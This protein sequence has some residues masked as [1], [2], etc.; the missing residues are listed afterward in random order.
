MKQTLIILITLFA[1]PHVN[2]AAESTADSLRTLIATAEGVDKLKEYQNLS[3]HYM[4]NILRE[5][6]IDTLLQISDEM[7]AEARRQ[8][9]TNYQGLA[10]SNKIIS[11]FNIRQLDK[12]IADAPDA[13]DRLKRLEEWKY[14]YIV[15][16][17][18][19]AVYSFQ[20]NTA[21]AQ[22]EAQKMYDDAKARADNAGMGM[23]LYA[24]STVYHKLRRFTNQE[25]N[26]REALALLADDTGYINSTVDIYHRL[27]TSLVLQTRHTEAL[28]VAEEYAAAIRRYEELTGQKKT[29]SWL[30]LYMLY[31]DLYNQAGVPDSALVYLDKLESATLGKRNWSESR[32]HIYYNQKKYPEAVAEADKAIAFDSTRISAKSLKLMALMYLCEPD[33][34]NKMYFDVVHHLHKINNDRFTVELDKIRTEY[35]VDKHIAEK[36]RTRQAYFLTLAICILLVLLVAGL[37]LY[38]RAINRKNRRLYKQI[39]EQ[40]KLA[41]ELRGDGRNVPQRGSDADT[42]A[43]NLQYYDLVSRL[44]RYLLTDNNLKRDDINRDDITAALATNRNTLS[45][46]VKTVTGQTLMEYIRSMQLDEARRLMDQHPELTIDTIAGECGFNTNTFYRVF[47]KQYDMS[48]AEYRKLG[49]EM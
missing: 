45:E 5:N 10:I 31:L 4:Q 47:R 24:M 28:Q 22:E 23:S 37:I 40:D 39:K 13:L 9:N 7:E 29:N 49:K 3:N 1:I 41:D 12:A 43:D 34:A 8:K 48:P 25:K 14:Y 20:N 44:R 33:S 38:N 6:A 15:Y 42:D 18:L 21:K 46:A 36:A 32:A 19:V 30:N 35:E 27:G 11:L 16:Y 17:N 26:L 2:H